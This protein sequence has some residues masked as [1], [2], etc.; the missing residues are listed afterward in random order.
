[1]KLVFSTG[2]VAFEI[3][4]ATLLYRACDMIVY[5]IP[6]STPHQQLAYSRLYSLLKR[7]NDLYL[8]LDGKAYPIVRPSYTQAFQR[9]DLSITFYLG[10][11]PL[12]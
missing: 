10:E 12:C 8:Q 9:R 3:K 6:Q 5:K 11:I 1:M 2:N 4:D 7:R